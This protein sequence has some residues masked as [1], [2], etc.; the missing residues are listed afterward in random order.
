MTWKKDG[1][2]AF[3]K[4]RYGEYKRWK[5]KH[6]DVRKSINR[7][8]KARRLGVNLWLPYHDLI[9]SVILDA[10]RGYCPNC[11]RYVGKD[12]LEMDHIIP[13][14]KGGWHVIW[15]VQPLCRRCNQRKLNKHWSDFYRP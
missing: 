4:R 14:S 10:T 3:K 1:S 6:L 15:N 8:Y 2:D 5:R 12:K 7:R 13:L 11:G 9:W